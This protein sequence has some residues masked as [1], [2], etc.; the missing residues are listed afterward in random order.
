MYNKQISMMII[1]LL[2]SPLRWGFPLTEDLMI[3]KM[4]KKPGFDC[5]KG[6]Y[7]YPPDKSPFSRQALAKPI[8][9]SYPVD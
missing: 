6:G 4:Q 2:D 3:I 5:S 1:K 8:V 7:S 9:T